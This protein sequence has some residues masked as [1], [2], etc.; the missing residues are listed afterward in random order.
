MAGARTK[1]KSGRGETINLRAS[2]KQKV[3]I[4]RAAQALGRSRSDFMLDTACREAESVLLDRRYFALSE[5]DFKR[6]SSMLD[7]PPKDNL[8]LRRLLQTK[9]PW[10]R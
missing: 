8:K 2:Q 9:P 4:D 1:E 6:F 7:N 10:E 3:L 5:H